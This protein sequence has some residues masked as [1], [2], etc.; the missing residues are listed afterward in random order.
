[1]EGLIQLA[2]ALASIVASSGFWSYL[3]NERKRTDDTGGLLLGIAH[4][5]IIKECV[6][7]IERGH[8]TLAEY[9]TL[10]HY[11][12]GPY[13]AIGGNGL[14]EK[15]VGEVRNLPRKSVM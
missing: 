12:Y 4:H 11:L 14:T 13:K 8:I 2:I 10:I 15:L 3:R 9:E 5:L 7:Y 1:M 6:F